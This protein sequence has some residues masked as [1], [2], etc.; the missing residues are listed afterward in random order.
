MLVTSLTV[1][2]DDAE[3]AA[4]RLWL[5]GARA[6]EERSHGP[7]V[8]L[9]T[10]L[11]PD[12][13]SLRSRI[14]AL[15]D[16]WRLAFDEVDDRASQRWRDFAVPI[17]VGDR[18]VIEPAW[19][20][21]DDA[22]ERLVVRIDPGGAFGLGDHPTT[23]LSAAAVDR[24]VCPG[25]RVLDVGCGSGV[26]AVV[27]ARRGAERVVAID[28][29]DEARLA[30]EDNARRN[31]VGDRVLA[32]TDDLTHVVGEYDVVVANI[33]APSLIALADGLVS[34]TAP[35]GVLVISG[36]LEG[37]YAHVVDALGMEVVAEDLLEGWAAVTLR[38][39]E[40]TVP[41]HSAG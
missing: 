4:D 24:L 26:L 11:G 40:P 37:R 22:G 7:S 41:R 36:V 14:G 10:A 8:E 2:A 3:L 18:L 15:P 9:R 16:H 32:S 39:G 30:T 20:P 19:R 25:D 33:L 6:V 34:A 1:P 23:R 29:A 38:H 35:D 13:V 5:L 27:A 21:C 17:I 28:V 12:Q 31:G